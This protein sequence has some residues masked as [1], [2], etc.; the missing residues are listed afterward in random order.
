MVKQIAGDIH[1]TGFT[2]SV[3][4]N[5][6]V[7]CK[8]TPKFQLQSIVYTKTYRKINSI[9]IIILQQDHYISVINSKNKM[10]HVCIHQT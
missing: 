7:R 10:I 8:K 4:S 2:L 1:R 6:H 9:Y 3:C 5:I